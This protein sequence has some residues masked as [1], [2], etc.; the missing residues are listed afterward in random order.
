MEVWDIFLLEWSYWV[1]LCFGVALSF[2]AWY[3]KK[4]KDK[5]D[6]LPKIINILEMASSI[7]YA[8]FVDNLAKNYGKYIYTNSAKAEVEN[9]VMMLTEYPESSEII[10]QEMS[11][12]VNSKIA[13][14]NNIYLAIDIAIVCGLVIIII[15]LYRKNKK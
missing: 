11:Y 13:L 10:S 6:F 5:F 15:Y 14:Y 2:L 1:M 9:K 3:I 4:Y 12:D 7:I 8:I